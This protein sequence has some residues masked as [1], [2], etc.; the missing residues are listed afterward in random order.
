MALVVGVGG[1]GVA[2]WYAL[3][4]FDVIKLKKS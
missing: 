3:V 2:A 1:I 4:K